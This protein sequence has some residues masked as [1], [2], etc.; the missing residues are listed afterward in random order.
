MDKLRQYAP[1]LHTGY[2]AHY[3][4]ENMRDFIEWI[5]AQFYSGF[6]AEGKSNPRTNDIDGWAEGFIRGIAYAAAESAKRGLDVWLFDEWGFPTGTAGGKTLEANPRWRSKKLH[7][8]MDLPLEK[9][10]QVDLPVPARFLSAAVWKT[11]RDIFGAPLGDGKPL[12]P[13]E[14]RIRYEAAEKRERLCVATWEFDNF[15]TVGI[16]I[17]DPEDDKQGTLDLLSREGVARFISQMHERY[18]PALGGYFGKQLKGF[19]Y[20]EPFVSVPFPYTFDIFEE[21]RKVKGYDLVPSLPRMLAGLLP[22]GVLDYRDV[23]TSRVAE[24]FYG[25]MAEWCHAHGLEMVGHQDLDHRIFSLDSKSGHFFKNSAR[26]DAPGVDYIWDQLRPGHFADFPRFAGSARR[27]LGK[28]HAGSESFAATSACLFPDYMRF[29][30]EFQILRGIDRFYLMVADPVPEDR[31]FYTVLSKDHPQSIAFGALLNR[32]VALTNQLV[33]T[34]RPGAGVALYIP[35]GA[36]FRDMLRQNDAANQAPYLL[37]WKYLNRAAEILCYL[38]VDF[39]YIWKEALLKLPVRD[40]ALISP[41]GQRI[42]TLIIPPSTV[43]EPEI[44]DKLSTFTREGGK[45]LFINNAPEPFLDSALVVPQVEDLPEFIKPGLGLSHP[46]RLSLTVREA[47]GKTLYF[48]L[49]EDSVP[50]ATDIAFPGGKAVLQYDY[51]RELWTDVGQ[52]DATVSAVFQPMELALYALAETPL[53]VLPR[54]TGPGTPVK[55][56]I[57]LLPDGKELPLGEDLRDWG[58]FYRKDYTGWMTYRGSFSVPLDGT[59]RVKLGRVCYAAKVSVDGAERLAAFAPYKAD[60]E[61]GKGEHSLQVEVLNTSVNQ[62]LGT[63]EA[64]R[65][66]RDMPWFKTKVGSDRKYLCSGLLGPVR[67]DLLS[68]PAS[69]TG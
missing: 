45:L 33:N 38:P 9:G 43:E 68:N 35:M 49:N 39:E 48:I 18:V 3:T 44:Y 28:K 36:V 5:D 31:Q 41:E 32:R 64:E 22:G 58:E 6:S 50:H 55:D 67:V 19:F 65:K 46:S 1:I 51:D 13:V 37:V 27:F 26:S 47:E 11:G 57:V 23:C 12:S 7:L 2:G 4:E 59:Y 25:Q 20:D 24:V 42:H 53:K 29:C 56:W 10:Q 17:P 66:N 16:F 21:F 15:R 8:A 62:I 69:K 60:F 61:L 14:G 34:A 30:M 63:A 40:G 54:L 52:G